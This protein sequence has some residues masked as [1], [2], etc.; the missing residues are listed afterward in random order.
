M[1]ILLASIKQEPC[2]H[3]AVYVVKDFTTVCTCMYNTLLGGQC[4]D[5]FS[6]CID[7]LF[8][9]S[10]FFAEDYLRYACGVISD[11][12]PDELADRLALDYPR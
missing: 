9:H 8:V 6:P 2:L 10:S 12:L 5:K 11:Y 4:S 1:F 7:R 3:L